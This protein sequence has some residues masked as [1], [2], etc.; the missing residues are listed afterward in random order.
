ML[1]KFDESMPRDSKWSLIG[2][3]FG[4]YVA[5][6]FYLL[7]IIVDSVLSN[8]IEIQTPMF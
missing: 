1:D 5:A 8:V 3:S 4:G 6:R 2:S 7:S